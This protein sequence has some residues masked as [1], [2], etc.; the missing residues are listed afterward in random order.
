MNSPTVAVIKR[1]YAVSSNRCAFPKCQNNLVD[2][3]SGKVVGRI[4]HIAAS[5]SGGPRFDSQQTDLERHSFENLVLMCPIHH[6][7]IDSDPESYTVVRLKSIKMTH[8]A[9]SSANQSIADSTANQFISLLIAPK[10]SGGSFIHTVNQSGGQVAHSITNFGPLKRSLRPDIGKSLSLELSKLPPEH[11]EIQ[12][13]AGDP[14]ARSL[15]FEIC[16]AL[17]DGG[18]LCETFASSQFP[19][20]MFGLV[21]SA[22]RTRVS[23]QEVIEKFGRSGLDPELKLLSG[24]KQINILVGT[25][26]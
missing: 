22:K 25:Q 3:Q 2:S 26:R 23:V 18:W 19:Q 24:L 4:C 21:V 8:E 16:A 5:S 10:I 1:L 20:P 15:A 7:V 12:S 13:V 17:Q 11:F 9:G 14:E 6:D